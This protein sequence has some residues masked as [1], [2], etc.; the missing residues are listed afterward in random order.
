M[1][2]MRRVGAVWPPVGVGL[3]LGVLGVAR[4]D[5]WVKRRGLR[6][7]AQGGEG[8]SQR[9]CGLLGQSLLH[10]HG[11]H[12]GRGG[13]RRQLGIHLMQLGGR[14]GA[15]FRGE[16][17]VLLLL[18]LLKVLVAG[19]GGRRQGD[20]TDLS[21]QGAHSCLDWGKGRGEGGGELGGELGS[22]PSGP[23]LF[24]LRGRGGG[25]DARRRGGGHTDV[26]GW[27]CAS[28][29]LSVL[30]RGVWVGGR[31]GHF[32]L[33]SG[34]DCDGQREE[35]RE[36]GGG[37]EMQTKEGNKQRRTEKRKTIQITYSITMFV[38]SLSV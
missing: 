18:Q 22:L 20:L 16:R 2:R 7:S 29:V 31:S 14:P 33:E 23:H 5:V 11:H 25:G 9:E 15:V 36:R 26:G 24:L 1:L 12:H 38:T 32:I 3:V 10:G 19:R 6:S 21:A 27:Q 37:E 35:D 8:M 30:W 17:D 28:S 13:G 4:H 34:N